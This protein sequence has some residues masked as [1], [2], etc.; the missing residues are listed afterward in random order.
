MLK[1]NK[2]KE[3]Y[4]AHFILTIL[5]STMAVLMT[6]GL[7]FIEIPE[8]NAQQVYMMLGIV[9]GWVTSQVSYYFGKSLKKEVDDGKTNE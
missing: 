9:A 1:S 4:S 6:I 7:F 3:L 5:F 2:V 8:K